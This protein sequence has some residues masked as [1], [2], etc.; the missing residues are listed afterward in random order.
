MIGTDN[1][2]RPW[3]PPGTRPFQVG[4]HVR[5]R[6]S[7]ECQSCSFTSA[8]IAKMDTNG[9][10]GVILDFNGADLGYAD[11]PIRILF[12]EPTP[13]PTRWGNCIGAAYAPN[14]LE[15]LEATHE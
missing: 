12:D 9:K 6:L 10:T 14:E 13:S 15:L 3:I 5:I 11:H 2:F 4:D 8:G 1:D 7:G